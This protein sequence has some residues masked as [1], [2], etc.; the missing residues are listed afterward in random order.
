MTA[1]E[2]IDQL[3]AIDD[4]SIDVYMLCNSDCGLSK[5]ISEV[6]SYYATK[7]GAFG[8]HVFVEEEIP[9]NKS[10]EDYFKIVEISG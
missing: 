2:L 6:S 5:P 4:K 7:N 10:I 3:M 1:Q 8:C 9:D